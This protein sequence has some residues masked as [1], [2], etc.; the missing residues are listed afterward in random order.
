[1]NSINIAGLEKPLLIESI[2]WI[3]GEGN[4]ARFHLAGNQTYLASQTLKHLEHHL[5]AFVR[6]HKSALINPVCITGF[7][8]Q[9]AKVAYV[10]MS[11]GQRI[12]L[13]YRRIEQVRSKLKMVCF[14]AQSFRLLAVPADKQ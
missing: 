12:Q 7:E 10:T 8:Q 3:E 14:Q 2:I 6:I 1:M 11:N 13:A 4:Y 5:P 9:K